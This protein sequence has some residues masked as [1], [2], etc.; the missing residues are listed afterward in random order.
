MGLD[1]RCVFGSRFFGRNTWVDRGAVFGCLFL[2]DF[3]RDHDEFCDWKL[4]LAWIDYADEILEVDG[5]DVPIDNAEHFGGRLRGYFV[6]SVSGDHTFAVAGDDSAELWFSADD[7][8]FGRY[9]IAEATRTH[10]LSAMGQVCFP[11]ICC[12]RSDCRRALLH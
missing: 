6:P 10:R 5:A 11:D 1:F 4:R 3:F 2:C 9:K 8:K 12:H 7:R